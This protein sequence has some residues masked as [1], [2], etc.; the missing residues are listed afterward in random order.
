MRMSRNKEPNLL[1]LCVNHCT[2]YKPGKSEE[3]QCQG[4][5]AVQR[6]VTSGKALPLE[7]PRRAASPDL[8]AR[9]GL[10]TCVCGPC[11][12]READCD[13]ILTGGTA[14]PCGGF[15]LLSHLLGSGVLTLDEIKEKR[16]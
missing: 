14:P 1:E 6:I 11:A 15:A 2:Y 16:K 3:L 7:R 4:F 9:E 5:V 12:F 13:F 10:K 8:Q